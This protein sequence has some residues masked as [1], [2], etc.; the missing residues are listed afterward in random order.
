MHCCS[1]YLHAAFETTT[2]LPAVMARAKGGR[3]QRSSILLSRGS[4]SPRSCLLHQRNEVSLFIR[5]IIK[6]SSL[7]QAKHKIPV[8][9]PFPSLLTAT[10]WWKKTAHLVQ[11]PRGEGKAGT[12]LFSH[13][14]F[15]GGL[16]PPGSIPETHSVQALQPRASA[17]DLSMLT[18]EQPCCHASWYSPLE[19]RKRRSFIKYFFSW[20]FVHPEKWPC[21]M[22]AS[23]PFGLLLS[24][25]KVPGS[26]D[27]EGNG[28][29]RVLQGQQPP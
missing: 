1:C 15:P 22:S 26:Q 17:F 10:K 18:S 9:H 23:W 13:G 21:G 25:E 12:P 14:S 6:V 29:R 20:I 28:K 27:S 16:A 3:A 19:I 24:A 11:C 7:P 8:W 5:Q 2:T 4:C